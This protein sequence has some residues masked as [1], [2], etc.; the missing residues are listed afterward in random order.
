MAIFYID[1]IEKDI[2]E[3]KEEIKEKLKKEKEVHLFTSEITPLVQFRLSCTNIDEKTNEMQGHL[4]AL[5]YDTN[6]KNSVIIARKKIKK[7]TAPDMASAHNALMIEL[8]D[9]YE[10]EA[11]GFMYYL[12]KNYG[13]DVSAGIV[14]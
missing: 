12:H 11:D 10:K 6:N 5:V 1:D 14:C 13:Y 9:I 2:I 7:L 3:N 8:V 4:D